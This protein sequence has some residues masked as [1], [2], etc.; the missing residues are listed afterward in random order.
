MVE[1]VPFIVPIFLITILFVATIEAFSWS[2]CD[3]DK[4]ILTF[5]S[6]EFNDDPVI[7]GDPENPV[8]LSLQ[9]NLSEPLDDQIMVK[10]SISKGFTIFG[11]RFTLPAFPCI[12]GYGSCEHNLCN[13]LTSSDNSF[14]CPLL[15]S[16]GRSCSCPIEAGPL[17]VNHFNGHMDISNVPS[18][19]L[20]L[21]SMMYR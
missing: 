9:A 2:N 12:K 15:S 16:L 13:Y 19:I 5:N 10:L 11:K 6:I 20:W 21:S 3:S 17:V 7:I 18:V 1:T 4:P 8:Q 14:G